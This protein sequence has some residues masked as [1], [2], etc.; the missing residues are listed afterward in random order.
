MIP[1]RI[2]LLADPGSG[3]GLALPLAGEVHRLLLHRPIRA[4]HRHAPLYAGHPV[5]PAGAG[6]SRWAEQQANHPPQSSTRTLR[7]L[8]C[9]ALITG[10]PA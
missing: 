3:P 2:A 7:E 8:V 5:I 1:T 4:P 9:G 10:S 6:K